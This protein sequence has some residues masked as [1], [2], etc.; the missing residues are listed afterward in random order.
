MHP[1]R[2]TGVLQRNAAKIFQ[3]LAVFIAGLVLTIAG[4]LLYARVQTAREPVHTV[5]KA[6]PEERASLPEETKSAPARPS[7]NEGVSDSSRG[8]VSSEV[9]GPPNR[10]PV[11]TLTPESVQNRKDSE[12]AVTQGSS[13]SSRDAASSQLESKPGTNETAVPAPFDNSA[14]NE[15]L[16]ASY[17]GTPAETGPQLSQRPQY[18]SIQEPRYA[19][20]REAQRTPEPEQKPTPLTI[21][22]GT[23]LTIRLAETLSSGRNRTGDTFRATLA[24]PLV[25][26]GSI[27]AGMGAAVLGRVVNARRAPLIG[28]RSNL[29][30]TLTHITGAED[31]L[32]PVNTSIVEERGSHLNVANTAKMATGAVVG[33][34]VGAVRGAGEGSGLSSSLKDGDAT[35]GFMATSRT[36]VLP[37]GTQ[38]IFRLNAALT[39]N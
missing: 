2:A 10:T 34:V 20:E 15:G 13:S 3:V 35:N 6:H 29:T 11:S 32:V 38:F 28:G 16:H 23:I 7:F 1:S 37:A 27:V 39:L 30:L 24:S 5:R 21:P 17:P 25:V 8:A 14:K 19:P 9:A 36:V 12:L 31:R 4:A 26:N 18:A 22:E 33:A